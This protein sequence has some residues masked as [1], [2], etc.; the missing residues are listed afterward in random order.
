MRLIFFFSIFF[1]FQANAGKSQFNNLDKLLELNKQWNSF[2]GDTSELNSS[3]SLNTDEDVIMFHLLQVEK[4]LRK[5]DRGTMSK[6]Q[7]K[8]RQLNLEKLKEYA[9]ERKFPKNT[10][11][12]FQRVPYFIDIYNTPCAVGHLIIESGNKK[13]AQE[14]HC[15]NNNGY[16]A[17]LVDQFSAISKWAEINGFTIQE[18]AWIQ[19]TY[20]NIALNQGPVI[21]NFS[22]TT[23]I[24]QPTCYGGL[25]TFTI[26]SNIIPASAKPYTYTGFHINE[27]LMNNFGN[28]FYGNYGPG[29]NLFAGQTTVHIVGQ[30]GFDTTIIILLTNPPKSKI[31]LLSSTYYSCQNG[32]YGSIN[33]LG[34][35]N[36]TKPDSV[37]LWGL[38]PNYWLNNIFYPDSLGHVRINNLNKGQW[39]VYARDSLGCVTD[40]VV[41]VTDASFDSIKVTKLS[42]NASKGL[43][44][45]EAYSDF[46]G[47]CGFD[48]VVLDLNQSVYMTNSFGCNGSDSEP[49][50]GDYYFN[51]TS[52]VVSPIYCNGD[53]ALI[54]VIANARNPQTFTGTGVIKVPGGLFNLYV[55]NI[56]GCI[57]TIK[58][59]L[60][61]P[62]KVETSVTHT[63][64]N[65]NGQSSVITVANSGGHSPYLNNYNTGQQL[66]PG[67]YNIYSIDY[68][69]CMGNSQFSIQEP[70]KIKTSVLNTE[71]PCHGG[72]NIINFSSFGGHPPYWYSMDSNKPVS[73]GEYLLFV[74]DS[75]GCTNFS[76]FT[77]TEPSPINISKINYKRKKEGY[78]LDFNVVGGVGVYKYLMS[79]KKGSLY[80]FYRSCDTIPILVDD[81]GSYKLTVYD[82]NLCSKDQ[83]IELWPKLNEGTQN[84]KYTISPNPFGDFLLINNI[85]EKDF[86]SQIKIIDMFGKLI[87]SQKAN[88]T[89]RLDTKSFP[90]GVYFIIINEK[91]Y[92]VVKI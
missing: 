9:Q 21:I 82:K 4:E 28:G 22:D 83:L 14:I 63:E 20:G 34:F 68:F 65:C 33:I 55:S 30:N 31:L 79:K 81:N 47:S 58:F 5:V 46:Y 3:V 45:L 88:L 85:Q 54:E 7:F 84:E 57:D 59:D 80:E 62:Q 12:I 71:I 2:Q 43:F 87:L 37:I 19:P 24:Y 23:A 49:I 78:V 51:T 64:L 40:T 18:L 70:E 50:L 92:K 75:L 1:C 89:N 15:I 86:G 67:T 39:P 8:N 16:I 90:K 76:D 56:Y 35:S 42:C 25:G 38:P 41:T 72:S 91:S 6:L 77:I 13:L 17:D 27:R 26:D 11:H 29:S 36:G 52:A 60:A 69:G 66:A 61:E 32:P 48:T 10:G 53:S 73:A 44:A 74:S